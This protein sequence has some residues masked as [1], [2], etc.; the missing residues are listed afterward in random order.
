MAAARPQASPGRLGALLSIFLAPLWG[1]GV[2]ACAAKDI[3][4]TAEQIER[5]RIEL[6]EVKA[7]Q[8]E[9]VAVLS[10]TVV[11]PPNGRVAVSAPFAGTVLKAEI[12]PGQNVKKGTAL[13][14]IASRDLMEAI[15]RLRQAEA[16][17]QAAEAVAERYRILADKQITARNRADETA[18]QVAKARAVVD[19]HKRLLTINS[20]AVNPDGSYTV[21][22]PADGRIVEAR[23]APGGSLEAMAAAVVIDTTAELWLEAQVPVALIGRMTVGNTVVLANGTRGRVMSV[24][25]ALDPVTRSGVMLVQLPPDSGL[26]AGQMVGLTVTHETTSGA[27]SVPRNA[28]AVIAGEPAV[29]VRTNEGF[30][31]T[32]VKVRGRSAETATIEGAVKAG[33]QVAGSG[34]AQLE[35]MSA[36]E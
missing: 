3:A 9:A 21:K 15:S 19:Q 8:S 14:T 5:L 36:G 18:A 23:A 10:A 7:A 12:L 29:F 25:G 11:P 35:K 27:V 17:V 22:A 4:V 30:A 28:V 32:P 33:Q 34:L 16:E 26:I 13:V 1:L 6:H 20:I 2:P 24:G 31:L